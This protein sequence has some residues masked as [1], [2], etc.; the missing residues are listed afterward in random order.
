MKLGIDNHLANQLAAH[1][2]R[3]DALDARDEH[4]D[5][6]I[7]EGKQRLLNNREFAGLTFA[8]FNTYYCG[9]YFDGRHCD[10]LVRFVAAC[11]PA[12]PTNKASLGAYQKFVL[13]ALDEFM[14]HHRRKIEAAFDAHY[15][16]AA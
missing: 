4:L 9:E 8:D 11:D 3:L 12:L 13:E 7:L 16:D 14:A 10:S 15:R 6:F 2:K 1:T 5:A